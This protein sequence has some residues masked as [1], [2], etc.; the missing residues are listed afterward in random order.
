MTHE[1]I[2]G[3]EEFIADG[4]STGVKQVFPYGTERAAMHQGDVFEV[5]SLR[6]VCKIF[7]IGRGEFF[8]RPQDRLTGIRIESIH[9]DAAY[10][11]SIMVAKDTLQIGKLRNT[12]DA[13]IGVWPVPNQI[14]QA[15]CGIEWTGIRMFSIIEYS[16]EGS[17]VGMD[18]RDDQGTHGLMLA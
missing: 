17:Q 11:C 3:I 12:L 10:C 5:H 18:I 13:F 1:T 14:A 15:P 2:G 16:L 9:C 4:G 7:L 8:L 6:Q